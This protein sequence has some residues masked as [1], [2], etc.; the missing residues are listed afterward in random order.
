MREGFLVGAPGFIGLLR[1][2]RAARRL[3]YPLP[4]SAKGTEASPP[5]F[6][7]GHLRWGRQPAILVNQSAHSH[8][9]EAPELRWFSANSCTCMASGSLSF[10]VTRVSTH[11]NPQTTAPEQVV[12]YYDQIAGQYD[13]HRFGNSLPQNRVG[14]RQASDGVVVHF[15]RRR[16]AIAD[17]TTKVVREGD[18]DGRWFGC[19]GCPCPQSPIQEGAE[20]RTISAGAWRSRRNSRRGPGP[21]ARAARAAW[22]GRPCLHRTTPCSGN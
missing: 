15:G 14:G 12:Q 21:R 9:E 1:G 19:S 17:G 11:A 8:T 10:P 3:S 6:L 7:Q 5:Q 4:G 20:N 22:C 18:P 13:K 16:R 2:V